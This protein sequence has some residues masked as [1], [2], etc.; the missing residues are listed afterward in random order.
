MIKEQ[1]VVEAVEGGYATI[2][3]EIRSSCGNCGNAACGTNV[4][5]EWL[6]NRRNHFRVVDD[7]GVQAGDRV[8]IGMAEERLVSAALWVYLLPLVGMIGFALMASGLGW[9]EFGSALASLAGLA[10]GLALVRQYSRS[11]RVAESYRPLLLSRQGTW[12]IELSTIHKT[13]EQ[14]E[15]KRTDRV[16]G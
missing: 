13:G 15:R 14:H 10:A 5:A 4:L 8:T 3:T 2:R 6:G 9:G 7:L 12:Q 1:G 16:A 11:K